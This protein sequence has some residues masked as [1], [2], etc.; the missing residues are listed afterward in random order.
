M[1]G[2]GRFT[3]LSQSALEAAGQILPDFLAI[4]PAPAIAAPACA[5]NKQQVPVLPAK[6][7][8]DRNIVPR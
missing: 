3:Y 7:C 1:F 4:L 6:D 2:S 5:H 8:E